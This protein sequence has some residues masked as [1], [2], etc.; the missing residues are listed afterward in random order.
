M[1]HSS[2]NFGYQNS[3][4]KNALIQ[5]LNTLPQVCGDYLHREKLLLAQEV[6]DTI[7]Q[8][9]GIRGR[10]SFNV[11]GSLAV[12]DA[13]KLVRKHTGKNK[14]AVMTGAYHGRS[15][16]TLTL[17][18]SHRYRQYF[19][20]FADRAFMF[21]FADCVQCYYDQYS[22][23][24]NLYCGQM[25]KKAFSNEFYGLASHNST[26]VGALFIEP[27]QGRGYSIPPRGFY[28]EFVEDLRSRGILIVADEIQAGMF[29]T[30]RLFS[31]EHFGIIPDIIT[32][33]KSLTNGFAPLSLVWAREDLLDPEV[34]TPGHV[35]SNFA[36]HPLGTAAG[37]ATWR[38]M[39]GMN[40][41]KS[42]PLRGEYFLN[43]LRTL[44]ERYPCIYS[45][46]GLGLFLNMVFADTNGTPHKNAARI[47]SEIA[48]ENDFCWDGKNWRMLLS[49]GGAE[50]NVLKFA[51]Y[52]NIT[53]KEIDRT[54]GVLEQVINQLQQVLG[55]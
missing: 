18:S 44:Q 34:V 22:D 8:R 4:I 11:S 31:F 24:C 51:P 2:C 27:C 42:I 40:Y 20:E 7:E 49:V 30:G 41:A 17:S 16:G 39:M 13:L 25:I 21:P 36:N 1:W 9:T 10:I 54:I 47:A 5:Q 19:N 6:A 29:R 45:V 32:L 50:S 33:S 48:Q 23:T 53:D 3:V 15:L 38:Y 55:G 35:H 14:V 37:L 28:Q 12:E 46:D 43:G 26:E 52:L